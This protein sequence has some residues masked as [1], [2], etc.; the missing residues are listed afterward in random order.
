MCCEEAGGSS[1]DSGC[2]HRP[3]RSTRLLLPRLWLAD[4]THKQKNQRPRYA[5]PLV[6]KHHPG[7][8]ERP[9]SLTHTEQEQQQ[10]LVR[11]GLDLLLLQ[12][13]R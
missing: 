7:S 11:L 2:F 9:Q 12:F 10:V 5:G 8:A 1:E 13:P 4:G 6:F 3:L